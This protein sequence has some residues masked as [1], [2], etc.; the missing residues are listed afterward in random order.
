MGGS[1]RRSGS[2]RETTRVRCCQNDAVRAQGQ[3]A[4]KDG[5]TFA[6]RRGAGDVCGREKRRRLEAHGLEEHD[7]R[8]RVLHLRLQ[9][10]IAAMTDT[11][12]GEGIRTNDEHVGSLPPALAAYPR[13]LYTL[14]LTASGLATCPQANA[15]R[16][17]RQ[18]ARP[19]SWLL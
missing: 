12:Y 18:S 17:A 14:V 9:E 6:L 7:A 8:R 13:M 16:G 11:G 4:G 10:H 3:Q 5:R 19:R 15:D 2:I 1:R